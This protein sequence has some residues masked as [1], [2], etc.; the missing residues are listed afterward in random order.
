[1]HAESAA[2]VFANALFAFVY[3]GA[4]VTLL[5]LPWALPLRN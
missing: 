3:I 2:E 5:V 1:M 4:T